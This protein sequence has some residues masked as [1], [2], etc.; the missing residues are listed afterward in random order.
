LKLAPEAKNIVVLGGG[1]FGTA[2]A[3]VLARKA[4]KVKILLR[5]EEQVKSI[6][7]KHIAD[8]FPDIIL[9]ETITATTS[10]EEALKG[11]DFIVHAVPVQPS[12]EYLRGLKSF[13]SP[14]IPI[15]CVSKGISCEN[16]ELMSGVIPKALERAQPTAFLAGPSFAKGI[17]DDHPTS[18]SVASEDIKLAEKVQRLFSSPT[19]RVFTTTDVIGVEI[20]AALKNVLAIVCGL[21]KGLG[22]G[23]N[24]QVAVVTR[25]W[26]DIRCICAARGAKSET[27]SGLGGLGDLMLT[28]FGGLSRNAKFGEKLASGCTIKEAIEFV[29]QVVEGYPTAGAAKRLGQE[30]HLE[31]PVIYGIANCLEGKLP[32][33]DL[34]CYI[35]TLPLSHEN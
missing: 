6:N 5:R 9:P 7:E 23:P 22:Y 29:G 32:A 1:V 19:F 15:I 4:H 11:V 26:A 25:G 16:L 13:I 27:L 24:T 30:L 10:A 31:L 8:C 3:T 18:V 21:I 33:R 20:G 28:C 2:M 12:F 35:M 14:T 17:M 34:V